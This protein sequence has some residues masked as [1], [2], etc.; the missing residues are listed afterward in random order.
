MKSIHPFALL[1]WFSHIGFWICC[2]MLIQN[3]GHFIHQDWFSRL[4]V[5]V[6]L[7]NLFCYTKAAK[8]RIKITDDHYWLFHYQFIPWKKKYFLLKN[9]DSSSEDEIIKLLDDSGLLD[10]DL[11][12]RNLARWSL[13]LCA[14]LMNCKKALNFK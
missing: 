14:C 7:N 13:F 12:P 11:F 2:V 6:L 9:R 4:S 1:Y 8:K 3:L 5:P 10:V